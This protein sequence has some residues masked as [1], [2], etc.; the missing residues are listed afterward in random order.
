MLNTL[1]MLRGTKYIAMSDIAQRIDKAKE[2][3][4]SPEYSDTKVI[5]IAF[6][7]GYNCIRNF[8]RNFKNRTNMC[9]TEYRIFNL[10]FKRIT[11]M[12]PTEYN[13]QEMPVASGN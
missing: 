12:S 3:L 13:R 2:L 6:E 11:G 4:A 7:V 10:H 1:A 5:D 9:P 8:N